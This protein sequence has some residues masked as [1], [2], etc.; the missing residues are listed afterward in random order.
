MPRFLFGLVRK[1]G[2]RLS[3]VRDVIEKLREQ[4]SRASSG[5]PTINETDT[6]DQAHNVG[7][8]NELINESS[9]TENMENAIP[10]VVDDTMNCED[11]FPA[12]QSFISFEP[13]VRRNIKLLMQKFKDLLGTI[14]NHPL[15]FLRYTSREL[16]IKGNF[17]YLVIFS[18]HVTRAQA[19]NYRVLV[20]N[21]IK[22]LPKA[23]DEMPPLKVLKCSKTSPLRFL[24]DDI[25][26]GNSINLYNT[27]KRKICRKPIKIQEASTAIKNLKLSKNSDLGEKSSDL[28]KNEPTVTLIDENNNEY[29]YTCNGNIMSICLNLSTYRRDS[30]SNEEENNISI[31]NILELRKVRMRIRN[32]E[33]VLDD[34][35][36]ATDREFWST[37]QDPNILTMRL[38]KTISLQENTALRLARS[39]D[40]TFL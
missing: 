35:I 23:F 19:I 32:I 18:F 5:S 39:I 8:D 17:E 2:N 6:S 26:C 34:S 4:T 38:L 33:N 29:E 21:F 10:Y 13:E 16:R 30:S 14:K 15:I 40:E 12:V 20:T 22:K 1:P 36:I 28:G 7:T 37:F 11:L 24:N 25:S 9:A 27:I 3:V 31:D